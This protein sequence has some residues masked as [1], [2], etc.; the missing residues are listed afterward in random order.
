MAANPEDIDLG[1]DEDIGQDEAAANADD[2]DLQQ[3][4]VPVRFAELCQ[5]L[6][7]LSLEVDKTDQSLTCRKPYLEQQGQ[8]KKRWVHWIGLQRDGEQKHSSF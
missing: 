2:E 4:A 5:T 8:V 1:E 7:A 3:K 6:C